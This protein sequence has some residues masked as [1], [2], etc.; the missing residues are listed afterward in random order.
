VAGDDDGDAHVSLKGL[1]KSQVKKLEKEQQRLEK[2]AQKEQ[3]KKAVA[4]R[5]RLRGECLSSCRVALCCA[6]FMKVVS[7][8]GDPACD[9][10]SA[11]LA[12]THTHAT[13]SS[14]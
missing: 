13:R 11:K 14:R 2:K 6:C 8:C 9:L 4:E 3:E 1:K 10:D 5:K 7:I 12:R